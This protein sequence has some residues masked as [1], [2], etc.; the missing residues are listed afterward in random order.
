VNLQRPNDGRKAQEEEGE[1][2]V[3]DAGQADRDCGRQRAGRSPGKELPG[4]VGLI[5]EG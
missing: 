1:A 4:I 3:I 2:R 5:A